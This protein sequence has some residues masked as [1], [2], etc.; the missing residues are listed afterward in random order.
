MN[1]KSDSVFNELLAE[2]TGW[3]KSR[4]ELEYTLTWT[5]SDGD[6]ITI[7]S[8]RE[9]ADALDDVDEKGTLKINVLG[10]YNFKNSVYFSV[11][12]Q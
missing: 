6:V 7:T 5:D 11:R 3:Y 4:G 8:N 10:K 12:F 1:K 9:F 2:V